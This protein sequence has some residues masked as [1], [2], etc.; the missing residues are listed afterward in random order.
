[1]P[2]DSMNACDITRFYIEIS[3]KVFRTIIQRSLW[4]MRCVDGFR[5]TTKIS[6]KN[7]NFIA[8]IDRKIFLNQIIQKS[9]NGYDCLL[10]TLLVLR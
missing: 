3:G 10:K 1:M 7:N 2:D 4:Y 9:F 5:Q 6:G 8:H